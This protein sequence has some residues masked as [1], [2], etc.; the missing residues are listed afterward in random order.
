MAPPTPR[1]P[2]NPLP[3]GRVF[4]RASGCGS[5]RA[6]ARPAGSAAG[7][8]TRAAARAR[9]HGMWMALVLTAMFLPLTAHGQSYLSGFPD[10]SLKSPRETGLAVEGAAAAVS[11]LRPIEELLIEVEDGNG[12]AVYH[13][14]KERFERELL[15]AASSPGIDTAEFHRRYLLLLLKAGEGVSQPE[16]QEQIARTFTEYYPDGDAFPQA[17]FYLNQALFQQGKPMEESFFFDEE[18]LESLPSWMHTRF[19]RMQ[20]RSRERNGKFAEAAGLLLQEM[21]GDSTLG[22]STRTEVEELLERLPS[23]LEMMVFLEKHSDVDWLYEREPFLLAKTM[24]NDGQLDQALLMLDQ[25]RTDGMASSQADLKRLNDLKSEILLRAATRPER[26]GVLLPLGS[27]SSLLRSLAEETLEGLRLAVQFPG[28]APPRG[29]SLSR[30]LG[31]DI[32][33]GMETLQGGRTRPLE[34]ELVVRDTSNDFKAAERAVEALVLEEQVVAIIGPIARSESLGAIKKA[35]ELGVPLISFS[36][37]IDLP[38]GSRFVFR[39]SKSVEEEIRDLVRYAMDYLHKKRFAI[40]YPNDNYGRR[41]MDLFWGRVQERGGEV[42]AAAWFRPSRRRSR[43]ARQRVGFKEIFENF[44]GVNR[45]LQKEEL[46]LMKAVGDDKPDPIVDFDAIFIPV[47]PNGTADLQLIAPYPVTVDAEHVQLL[48]TRFWNDP[49]VIVA[50]D[51]KLDGA[52]F[53]DAFDSSNT[54]PRVAE[55]FTR[56]RTQFGHHDQYQPPSYYA[57]LG[58]DT[59]NMLMNLLRKPGNRGRGPLR[60][61]LRK[62]ETYFGV[63]GWTRFKEN[64]EAVKE[65]MFFRIQDNEIVRLIP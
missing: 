5:G 12:Q 26:I 40:L 37:S 2:C 25:I 31:Q 7:A 45:P 50:G 36:I 9:V 52:V 61:A 33:L 22:Q 64:G 51:G 8:A 53:V 15:R 38:P 19:L 55:F 63:T 35:E 17:F 44:T 54:N 6:C 62:M 27:R 4:G 41:M 28:G 47:G 10:H 49:A 14:L 32:P 59:A 56:H 34:F 16:A 65:S 42:V 58:Y 48:G 13:Q 3:P 43:G 30:L 21:N 23:P 24:I 11:S 29:A 18:A 46:E 39:H 20:A 1:L 60:D 57:G